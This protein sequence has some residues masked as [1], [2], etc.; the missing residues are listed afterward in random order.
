M[1]KGIGSDQMTVYIW[2]SAG[3]SEEVTPEQRAK[4]TAGEDI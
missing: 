3:L 2:S 1:D 4:W